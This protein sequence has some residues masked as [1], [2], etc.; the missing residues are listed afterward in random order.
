MYRR[1]NEIIHSP[2]KSI[3]Y[4]H[5]WVDQKVHLGFFHKI[6]DTFPFSPITLL[7]WMF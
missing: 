1:M 5:Y 3:E 6:K 7:I 4:L 2:Q